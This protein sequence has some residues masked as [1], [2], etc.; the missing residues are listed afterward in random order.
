MKQTT[1][2]IYIISAS[3]FS[4]VCLAASEHAIMTMPSSQPESQ[5]IEISPQ[6]LQTIGVTYAIA[7]QQELTKVIKTVG[8]IELD[9]RQVAHVHVKFSGWIEKIFVNFTG[10][11]V[12]KD[13]PLFSVYSPDLVT[14]QQ[15][16][17]LA[18]QAKK[19]LGDQSTLEAAYQRL[20]YWNVPAQFIQTL[21]K[22]G[23]VE[24]DVT[25][26]SPISGTVINKTALQG[27]KI[28][29]DTELYTIA[30]LS[31]LWILADIY[32]YELPHIKVGEQAMISLTYL[33]NQIFSAKISFI[34]PTV[35]PQTRTVKVRFE[36]T[37]PHGALKPGMYTNVEL[38][39][40]LGKHLV[41]PQNAILLTGERAVIFIY[42]GNG[43]IE[44]RNVKLGIHS[45]DWVE[46][47][48]GVKEGE[49]VI[50][51]AN[52]LLDAES[53]LK[54]AMGGMQH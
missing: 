24:K 38:K 12:K 21:T 44:W 39:I 2:I 30:D 18:L 32:E 8:N 26:Y 17:L 25:I 49:Q 7:K 34:N 20:L 28:M 11:E 1:L 4:P 42:L 48:S 29:Q 52:F 53:Q 36:I 10:E 15:E 9:E 5:I 54:G 23:K 22:T 13:Q 27:M 46:I 43:K 6:K 40:P 35:D 50:T 19:Q 31:K 16:Y 47:L 37:N 41:V 3:F 14:A 51:S 33:P 45:G